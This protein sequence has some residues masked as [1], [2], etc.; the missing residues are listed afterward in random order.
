MLPHVFRRQLVLVPRILAFVH[1]F[2]VDELQGI[3]SRYC[4]QGEGKIK[5]CLF[6]EFWLFIH[7]FLADELQGILVN[8]VCRGE[9]KT[10]LACLIDLLY[11]LSLTG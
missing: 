8:T 10:K 4:L 6:P 3:S 1:L 2:L 9:G 5:A 7:P 11:V